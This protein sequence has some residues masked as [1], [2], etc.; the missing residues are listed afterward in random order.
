MTEPVKIL[1]VDDDK[2]LRDLLSIVLTSSGYEV[3]TR[4]SGAAAL[5]IMESD[6][7][8]CVIQ[9]L[10]MP[11]MD[12]ITL[13]SKIKETRARLP[14][15]IITAFSSWDTAVEAMRLG[16]YDYIKKPFDNDTIRA[17]VA[18][19]LEQKRLSELPDADKYQVR[20]IVGSS[21]EIQKV[22][23]LVKR[24]AATDATVLITGESGSGKELVARAL[25]H[26]S[27][28]NSGPFIS[29]NCG[30]F[31]E[32]LLESEL[33][34]HIK[35]AFTGAVADKKGFFSIA[36]GGTL[37]LDEV[38]EL[39][40]ATQVKLLR[41][42]EERRFMPL[43]S[44]KEHS[45]DVRFVAATNRNLAELV[46]EG[47]FRNDLYYRLNVIP[48]NVPPLCDRKSDIAMLAGHFLR[49][50]AKSMRQD[51]VSITEPAM[52]TLL[53]YE[54]P[55]NVRELE[56][57]IQRAVAFATGSSI[58]M[59][60]LPQTVE[61]QEKPAALTVSIPENGIGLAE[62]LADIERSYIQE[63][64]IMTDENLTKAAE[65]L[66]MSFRSMRYKVKKLGLRKKDRS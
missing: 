4:D 39:A 16:A 32:N 35:G 27:L 13:L 30:A 58:E 62:T 25:H 55:G 3:V 41:V 64:L 22:Q 44:S 45:V 54:W 6:K 33:F 59:V 10:K 48:I 9:D 23:E 31:S 7:F 61:R 5:E 17:V 37:F 38:G 28:R 40:N 51:V 15:I 20:D 26:N 34:G 11:G 42:I 46:A 60:D 43:G 49:K 56:N 24:I 1:V 12:G 36:D 50:Y 29:V 18:R 52:Q 66:G 65:L 2:S 8:G 47:R 53:G 21:P 63:A 14:V 57:V 19:A